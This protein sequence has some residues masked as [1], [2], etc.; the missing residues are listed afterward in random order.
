MACTHPY[1]SAIQ[2]GSQHLARQFAKQGWKVHYISAPVTPF[3]LLKLFKTGNEIS[4]RFKY[5]FKGPT[6]HEEGMIHSYIPFSLMAPAGKPLLRDD[7]VTWH[8]YQ[9]M[10]PVFYNLRKH[11]NS[12]KVDLLYI[13][14]LSYHFLL[15][16]MSY[17][18]SIFR[19]M[20]IHEGFTGW[21]GK[22]QK[23]A[24]KIAKKTDLTVYSALG[25]KNYVESL[26]PIK[27]AFVPNGVDFNLFR[28]TGGNLCKHP[29]L[30]NISDPVILYTGMIDERV[31]FRLI[32]YAA[33]HL[34]K[35]SFVFTGAIER[36]IN[37]K[38][39]PENVYFTGSVPHSELPLLMRYS[40]AGMIPFDVNNKMNLIQG[41]RP[42]KL[43]EYMAAGLPVIAAT[44]PELNKMDSPAWCY[45][46]DQGFIDLVSRAVQS[47]YDNR[48][49]VNYASL[50]DW[51]LSFKMM[52][53]DL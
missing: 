46:N 23:L 7:I 17:D 36:S 44:W 11:I 18:K 29:L 34:P 16:Q 22:A 2:V 8:W 5:A 49:A 30:K 20:D 35:V 21:E 4:R 37:L 15:D 42:L 12:N 32:R 1:W 10:I 24:F 45:K 41:I 40:V 19:I 28:K 47:Q 43:M 38:N 39:F 9:T 48:S 53:N 33:K 25:L 13:D 31:D 3:H 51:D 26:K 52:L 14:N 50:H 27:S 6:I